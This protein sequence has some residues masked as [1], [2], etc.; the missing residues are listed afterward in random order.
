I[1]LPATTLERIVPTSVLGLMTTQA[2]L[3]NGQGAYALPGP[4]A[5]LTTAAAPNV[6]SPERRAIVRSLYRVFRAWLL[7]YY[8]PDELLTLGVK[9]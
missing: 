4:L 6:Q 5:E 2:L 3:Q 9:F 8:S 7:V 1:T